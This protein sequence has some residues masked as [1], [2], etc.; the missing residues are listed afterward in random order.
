MFS[1]QIFWPSL[2]PVFSFS[3]HCLAEYKFWILMKFCLSIIHF[4]G[5]AFGI[6]SKQT[7]LYSKS[8]GFS[9]ML[10][11]RSF[12]GLHYIYV[13]DP[14]W[15][16]SCK[17]SRPYIYFCLF[18]CLFVCGYPIIQH[19]LLKRLYLPNCLAFAPL[20]NIFNYV[21]W[22]LFMSF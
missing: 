10:S 20:S 8:S 2:C 22:G 21:Y 15:V 9:P 16:N 7:L 17:G 11:S 5:H 19:H 12:I 1:L 18:V 4:M 14:S 13:C 6:M 3:W